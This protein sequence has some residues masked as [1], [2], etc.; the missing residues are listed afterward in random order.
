M[1]RPKIAALIVS[2]NEEKRIG[3][4]LDSVK[5]F[6]DI[7]VA[8]K[9]SSDDTVA[10]AEEYG[11]KIYRIPFTDDMTDPDMENSIKQIYADTECEWIMLLTCSDVLHPLLYKKMCQY[12]MRHP[13]DVVR[14]PIVRYSMGFAHK[15]SYYSVYTFIECLCKKNVYISD[16]CIH[17][18][19]GY[20]KNTVVGEMADLDHK[21]AIYHLTHE[22]LELILERHLRYAKDEAASYI[23]RQDGLRQTWKDLIRQVYHYLKFRT[24]KLGEK[25]KAQLCMLLIYRSAKYLNVYFSEKKE[26][27]I[28]KVYDRIREELK[29]ECDDSRNNV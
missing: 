15:Y 11:T 3:Y 12:I 23:S 8:D 25:G 7:I 26:R 9:G 13:V 14:V 28:S 16:S 27:E 21:I 19:I 22:N 17:T 29:K 10:V 18:Y 24:F 6:D 2:Y 1:I 20:D 5:M 4:T